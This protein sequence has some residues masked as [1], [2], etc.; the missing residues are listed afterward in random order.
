MPH[1]RYILF[2]FAAVVFLS[3][4]RNDEYLAKARS[5]DSL[6]G[7][8]HSM[9]NLL[10]KVD[11]AL[12]DRSVT[13][14]RYYTQ[15][16]QQNVTDTLSKTEADQ[17]QK[18]LAAG[19]ALEHFDNNRKTILAR[20]GLVGSQLNHL[21]EDIRKETIDRKTLQ[22]YCDNEMHAA[23]EVVTAGQSQQK[24]F[25]VAVE[26]FRNAVSGVEQIIRSRN[27]GEL[28]VIVKDSVSL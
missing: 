16:I 18:F 17:L 20:A 26:E 28:P 15:F 1:V 3:C 19:R 21:T 9:R 5:I 23:G 4:G 25:H 11:T 2:F 24:L 7:A 10:V 27:H 14:Y 12:L 6:S 8:L 22:L 13:K